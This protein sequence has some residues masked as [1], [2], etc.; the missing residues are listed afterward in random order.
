MNRKKSTLRFIVIAAVTIDGK[1]AFNSKHFTNWTSKEDKNF[2]H[3]IL[4]TCDVV[5]VGHKTYEVAVKPLSERNCI[6]LTS[7]VRGSKQVKPNCLYCNPEKID[8]K[9][10]IAKFGYK[11]I[12]ILGG[13]QTYTYC[14][15]N[16]LL[17]EIFLTI[18][19]IVFGQ[20]LNLFQSKKSLMVKFTLGS[21]KKLNTQG[22]LLLHY[23]KV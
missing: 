2:L 6:V 21:V 18:E 16:K 5:V 7:K 3:K 20:G 12:A 1:I 17:N 19:P 9:G 14:L 4:D 22:S 13:S 10:L 8:L 15:E 11:K 23:V